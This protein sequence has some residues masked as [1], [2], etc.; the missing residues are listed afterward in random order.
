MGILNHV[1]IYTKD[2]VRGF[3]VSAGFRRVCFTGDFL[4]VARK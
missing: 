3:F 4:A 1:H 2:E